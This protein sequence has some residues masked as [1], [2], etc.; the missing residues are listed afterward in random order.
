MTEKRSM[1]KHDQSLI[2]SHSNPILINTYAKAHFIIYFTY[3]NH[4]R[5]WMWPKR[6][7][8]SFL[9]SNFKA[10]NQLHISGAIKSFKRTN[11]ICSKFEEWLKRCN[12]STTSKF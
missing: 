12:Y 5:S 11:S 1:I 4:Y 7:S 8:K 10:C 2:I 9:K 6:T 3:P